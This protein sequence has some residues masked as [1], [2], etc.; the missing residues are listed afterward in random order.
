M[1]NTRRLLLLLVPLAAALGP[2]AASSPAGAAASGGTT[3]ERQDVTGSTVVCPDTVLTVTSGVF[4]IVTHETL[5]PSGAYHLAVQANAQ[6]VKAVAPNGAAYQ[7]PGGFWVETNVTPGATT[8]NEV[9]VL[10]VVGQGGA[11]NFTVRGVVH[12]T[13]NANGNVTALVNH[14]TSTGDC[15]A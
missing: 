5:T 9:D 10:N 6:G 4:K 8:Q 14:F 7:V 13:V 11:P 2:I 12:L 1:N 3:I 15:T